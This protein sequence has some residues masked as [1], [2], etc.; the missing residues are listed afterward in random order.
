MCVEIVREH[1]VDS[2]RGDCSACLRRCVTEDVQCLTRL[3][4]RGTFAHILTDHHMA[5][6]PD[7]RSGEHTDGGNAALTGSF[8]NT[9]RTVNS[10]STLP[11]VEANQGVVVHDL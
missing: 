4:P 8:D 3:F 9:D 1:T 6:L 11:F 2:F 5:R 10:L 7:R